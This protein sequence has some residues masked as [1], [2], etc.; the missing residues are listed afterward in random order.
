MPEEDH[1]T[2]TARGVNNTQARRRE[3]E[4]KV[5]IQSH[6]ITTKMPICT[7]VGLGQL[8]AGYVLDSQELQYTASRNSRRVG[9]KRL[10]VAV[11]HP[12]A[13]L[14]LT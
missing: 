10:Q 12:T 2:V 13:L 8:S 9:D 4:Y 11:I 14:R 1:F 5:V 7:Y 6:V 3:G